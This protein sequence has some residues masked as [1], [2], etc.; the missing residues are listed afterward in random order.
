[1]SSNVAVIQPKAKSVTLDMADRFGM[2]PLAFEQTLRATVFPGNGSKEAFAAFLIVAKQYNLNPVLKEIYAFPAKG[3]GIVPIVSIDGWMNLIN[4]HPSF[5]GMDFEEHHDD[6]GALVSIRCTI[7]RKDRAHPISVTEYLSECVRST[8][9]WKMKHRMLRHKA[10]IQAA[11]YAFGFA[12]IYDEDEAER[13]V[14]AR[15]T[16]EPP[17]P[18]VPQIQSQPPAIEHVPPEPPVPQ[19]AALVCNRTTG[20]ATIIE[21][22]IPKG[23]DG[24]K[25]VADDARSEIAETKERLA[26][27]KREAPIIGRLREACDAAVAA[28]DVDALIEAWDSIVEPHISSN[29]LTG[30]L[31]EALKAVYQAAEDAFEK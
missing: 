12:G 19:G 21:P 23:A 14:E 1:M 18:P 9:P 31:Y 28:K 5:D 29:S 22:P 24:A 7:F 20:Q 10:A 16:I 2:E 11:R 26:P 25:R 15:Q 4:S 30:D 13:I 8:D 3:G 17:V 27:A 6:A